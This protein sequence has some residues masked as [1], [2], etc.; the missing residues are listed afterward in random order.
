[1]RILT[2]E[3]DRCFSAKVRKELVLG[4]KRVLVRARC[5]IVLLFRNI[6]FISTNL[7]GR[8]VFLNFVR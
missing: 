7:F 1:M 8:E 5:F 4:L 2:V 6:A 3:L